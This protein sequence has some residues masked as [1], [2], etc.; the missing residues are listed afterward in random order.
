M[1][2]VT[3]AFISLCLLSVFS[4][5]A[6]AKE[7]NGIIPLRSTV[8]DV[9][10][11]LGRTNDIN[12]YRAKYSLEKEDVFIVFA[13]EANYFPDCVSEL[14]IGT[15]LS[16]QVTPK[17]DLSLSDLNVDLSEF[18][19]LAPANFAE[20]YEGYVDEKE[21]LII[22]TFKGNIDQ[23]VY[24]ADSSD[25]DLCPELYNDPGRSVRIVVG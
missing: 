16:I 3:K 10:R 6:E 8:S 1:N 24:I 20:G 23:I 13:A 4:D 5:I 22:R 9:T 18:E 17:C 11:V 19:K 2:L 15:V 7:W 21:G 14:P 25:R 12:R